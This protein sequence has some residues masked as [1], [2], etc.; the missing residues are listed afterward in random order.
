[1][2]RVTDAAAS[3]L[4]STAERRMGLLLFER[5]HGRLI[6]T[7]EARRLYQDVE[8]L[9]QR[10]ERIEALTQSLAD[11]TSGTLNVAISP[12]FWV[13]VVPRAATKLL[14]QMPE[15]KLTVDLLQPHRLLQNL[16]ERVADVGVSL[17]PQP[18]PSLEII[19]QS[20]CGLVC[21]MRQNHPLAARKFVRACDLPGHPV[22]SFPH[23]LD[24]GLSDELLFGR[25]SDSIIRRLNVGSGQTECWFAQAGAG[26]A[27]V[28]TAAVAGQ[29]FPALVVRPYRCD[30]A[31][32]VYLLRHRDRPLSRAAERFCEAFGETWKELGS[33]GA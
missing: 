10:V 8:L 30:A 14:S 23:A 33:V 9:W 26:L 25:Y 13:T 5:K 29:A 4:L 31:V 15:L 28:D 16:V 24:F 19:D 3:K 17:N 1:M 21:V 27:I 20:R 32:Q 6:P 12:S 2:L 22:V 18:H 7:P 11:P